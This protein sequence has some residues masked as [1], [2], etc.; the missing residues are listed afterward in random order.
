MSNPNPRHTKWR[1]RKPERAALS[2]RGTACSTESRRTSGQAIETGHLIV[3]C[4]QASTVA[5]QGKFGINQTLKISLFSMIWVLFRNDCQRNL[6]PI[7]AGACR[8][9]KDPGNQQPDCSA[10]S[11]APAQRDRAALKAPDIATGRQCQPS[12]ATPVVIR[13]CHC[14]TGNAVADNER[15]AWAA[16][17][18]AQGKRNNAGPTAYA[19]RILA[20]Q[21]SETVP[22]TEIDIV[23]ANNLNPPRAK[24]RLRRRTHD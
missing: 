17:G 20:L 4:N 16:P 18:C 21:I 15:S 3:R 10:I 6:A 12:R 5:K 7:S 13:H 8:A 1:A 22:R 9:Q 23:Q 2:V 11:S 14:N 19:M 24:L